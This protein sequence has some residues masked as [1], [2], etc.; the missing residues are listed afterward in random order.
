MSG[1]HNHGDRLSTEFEQEEAGEL[2]PPMKDTE[3][4]DNDAHETIRKHD[5]F[6]EAP[7]PQ[8][9]PHMCFDHDTGVVE[10][11]CGKKS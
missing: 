6:K 7:N 10:N 11:D 5:Q 4:E 1:Y 9:S 2:A 3:D 8:D